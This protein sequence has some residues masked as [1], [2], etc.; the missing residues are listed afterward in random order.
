MR[1]APMC[2]YCKRF[3]KIKPGPIYLCEAFPNGVPQDILDFKHDHR[4][5]YEG[6]NGITF[7]PKEG[8]EKEAAEYLEDLEKTIWKNRKGE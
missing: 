7:E 4:K 5:P 6:D 8:L 1:M 2:H 3:I